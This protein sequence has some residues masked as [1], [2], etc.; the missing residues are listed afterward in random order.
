[1]ADPAPK[2]PTRADALAIV[3]LATKATAAYGRQDLG[4]RVERA[5]ARLNHAAFHVLVVGEFKQGKST[6]I[7]A[8][9]NAPVCAVDDDVATAVPTFVHHAPEPQAE[10]VW[11]PEARAPDD[12]TPPERTAVTVDEARR[13]VVEAADAGGRRA[14]QVEIGLPRRL[15]EGG[16]VLVDTPGVGGLGSAHT[17]TTIGALPMADAV[18]FVTDA[19]QELS[20]PELDFLR[21]ALDLCPHVVIV[22]TK[23]DFYPSWRQIAELDAGHLSR[24]GLNLRIIP[25][26]SALRQRAVATNDK[27]LNNESGF[28]PLV[29]H[30]TDEIGAKGE[31]LVVAAAAREVVGVTD[32]LLT[33]F[34]TEREVL[35]DPTAAAEVVTR[36]EAAKERADRL[37]S[38]LAKWQQTLGDGMSD[39]GADTDFDLR[40]RFRVVVRQGD[41][42]IDASDPLRSW[43]EFEP[44]LYRR[45]AEDLTNNYRFLHHRSREL[46]DRV[47]LHFEQDESGV[48]FE[49]AGGNPALVMQQVAVDAEIEVKGMNP[50][51]QLLSGVR[52]GYYGSLMFTALGGMAGLALGPV[53]V[54]AGI[55]L[56]RKALKD[57]KERALMGRRQTAKNAVRKYTDEVTFLAG[58]D[59]RGLLRRIQR[60]LRD[61]FTYRAEELQ[62]STAEALQATQAAAQKDQ[63]SRQARLKDVEAELN[64]VGQ[65]RA[66]A[67][68]LGGAA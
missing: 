53:A 61:H 46:A 66:R 24:L 54:G 6:L 20:A 34:E 19:S 17:T 12:D 45:V 48:T 51:M 60:Q 14:T 15:L 67:V 38:Q 59:S 40:A 44:W 42:A 10:V 33:H 29:A 55:I 13:L 16:L 64:R 32:Q 39:L 52:G 8:L 9:L 56:G 62:R 22:M 5:R 1:M 36:L 68:A 7:N 37:R 3:D 50:A 18:L 21:T 63:T 41:E 43:P 2:R 31:Q 65:L 23:I 11:E 27:D 57:E 35:T 47:A 25:V 26:S 58:N 49:L 30:L 4:A 28:A